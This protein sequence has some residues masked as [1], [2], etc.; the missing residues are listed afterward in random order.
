MRNILFLLF[1]LPVRLWAQVSDDF[2]DGDFTHDPAWSGTDSCF[3]V[4]TAGQLQSAASTAGLA[5]L[6][7][8]FEGDGNREW[9][10]WIREN[11]SPS[12]NNYADVWLV[13]DSADLRQA[14]S[15]FFMRFGAPGNND[16]VELYQKDGTM[17]TLVC[18]GTEGALAAP[19]KTSVKVVCDTL[20]NWTLSTD[21]DAA[22]S[23]T[24]EA[25]G[26]ASPC[27]QQG[28]FG[29]LITYT[30]SNAKKFYFDDIYV[31]AEVIDTVPPHWIQLEVRDA[32]QLQL[33]FDEPLSES[34]LEESHYLVVFDRIPDSAG[35]ASRPSEVSLFFDPPLP[36]NVM[37]QLQV[38][39]ISDLAGNVMADTVWGFAI[40]KA[41]INDVVINEVM[42]DPSPPVDLPECEYI[43]L[44]NTTAFPVELSGWKLVV[45]SSEKTF[46]LSSIAPEGYLLLGKSD[47]VEALSAFGP[48]CGFSS[49]SIANAG[50]FLQLLDPG[51]T[52]VSEL[53]FTDTWY[54]DAEKKEGGWSLEQIDPLHPCAGARNWT[55]SDDVSGGTPGRANSVFASNPLAP[56]VE[57]VSMLGDDIVLLWFDQQMDRQTLSVPEHYRVL[58]RDVTPEEVLCNPVN[59]A[60]VELVFGAPFR[61]GMSYTLLVE[62]VT[63]CSGDPVAPDTKV[64]FGIPYPVGVSEVLINEILFNPIEPGVDYV[65]LYNPTDKP[66]D[67]SELKLGVIK[68]SFPNLADTVCKPVSEDS[69]LMMPQTYLLLSTDGLGVARQYQCQPEDYLDMASFPPYPNA[70]GMALLVNHQGVVVDQMAFDE[71]MHHP[72]L[73]ETKGVALERVSWSAPSDQP[74]NWHSAAEAVH[75]GTPGYRNSMAV[76]ESPSELSE[77]VSPIQLDPE[78]F[79]PDGDGIDDLLTIR[80]ELETSGCTMNAYLF[81]ADGRLVRHL[82]RGELVAQ[83]GCFVWNG[84]DQ[85]GCGVPL[86][87]YVL[88]TE[89]FDGSGGVKRYRNVVAVASR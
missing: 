32:G 39:G 81:D 51:G 22:G 61:E 50:A 15:G 35:F 53:S 69:R 7:V 48:V 19:F 83:E 33:T 65:E 18:R 41:S 88:V 62:G 84:L 2:S 78:V 28:F 29:F 57:R 73:K 71:S 64:A 52:I 23:Y 3:K 14:S 87:I 11:F 24:L 8:P 80:Y 55:A 12:G 43:E 21:P 79:S 77:G 34:A 6:S 49:F 63:N 4:N 66:F 26:R 74:D 20:G 46:P 85:R 30:A 16:A 38:S 59:A 47:A 67:L 13:A 17:L 5:F 45:G 27:P 68:E 60:S 9:R 10:F 40:Y 76:G 56:Q 44:Y 37:L 89:V 36:E 86:G 31:G 25:Q 54:R 82:V 70:G 58:E 72:L 75:F 1:F 42:A